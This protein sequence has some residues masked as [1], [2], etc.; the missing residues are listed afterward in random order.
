MTNIF[1]K[2]PNE[3][4]ETYWEHLRYACYFAG[5]ML[6]AAI[7]GFIHAFFPFVFQ[8]TASNILIR[9]VKKMKNTKRWSTFKRSILDE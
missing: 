8:E 3:L 6:L 9:I 5:S 1:T 2:H 4:G 7:C